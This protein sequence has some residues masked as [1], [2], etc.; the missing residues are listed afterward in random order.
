[1]VAAPGDQVQVSPRADVTLDGD[2]VRSYTSVETVDGVALTRLSPIQNGTSASIRVLR[3]GQPIYRAIAAPELSGGIQLGGTVPSLGA[4]VR[5]PSGGL[6][7]FGANV[8]AQTVLQP[9]ALDASSGA[10]RYLWAA[11]LP[12]DGANVQSVHV[13][14]VRAPGG[15]AFVGVAV[16]ATNPDGGSAGVCLAEAVPRGIELDELV[17]VAGCPSLR[18]AGATTLVL[19]GPAATVRAEVLDGAGSV[20][21]DIALADGGAVIPLPEGARSV[22]TYDAQGT[23]GPE[24][25]IHRSPLGA[26]PLPGDYGDG[27]VD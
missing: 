11:Q 5:P 6:D 10:F 26:L 3:D 19:T 2:V 24:Q 15:G 23:S 4:P 12:S 16:S 25:E 21:A 17:V 18:D 1:M 7:S 20:M 9:L 14:A 13:V 27:L 22:R 8:A